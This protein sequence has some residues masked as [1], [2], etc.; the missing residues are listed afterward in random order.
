MAQT[1]AKGTPKN[2]VTTGLCRLSYAHLTQPHA[3]EAGQEPQYSVCLLIPK[4]DTATLSKIKAAVEVA[5]QSGLK[6]K[7]QNKMPP[8]LRTPLRDGDDERGGDPAYAGHY[9]I[10]ARS[11]QKPKLVDRYLQELLDESQVYSGCYGRASL[12]FYPYNTAGNKG[13]GCGLQHVQ[14]VRDGDPFGNIVRPEDA[15]ND[16]FDYG[17]DDIDFLG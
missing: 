16:D 2:V 7:W 3:V 17:D 10:N 14:K 15:F 1:A 5:K 9:F 8:N 11:K 12:S 6:S 13:V 4:S